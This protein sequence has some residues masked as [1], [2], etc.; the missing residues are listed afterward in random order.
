MI[1]VLIPCLNGLKY[2]LTIM[3]CKY[4]GQLFTPIMSASPVVIEPGF[5]PEQGQPN[6]TLQWVTSFQ[7]QFNKMCH[8]FDLSVHYEPEIICQYITV[9]GA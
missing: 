6:Y 7:W 5:T 2:I 1:V 9:K 8:K 4:N 3:K